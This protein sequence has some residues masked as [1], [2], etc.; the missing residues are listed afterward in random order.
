[1]PTADQVKTEIDRIVGYLVK[2]GLAG[3]QNYAIRRDMAGG[4]VE[5]SFSG[6]EYVAAAMKDRAYSNVY[7]QF[8]QAR[9]Y[10]AKMPDGALIQMLYKFSGTAIQR[11]R[12]AFFPSPSL[13]E[14]QN[15]PEIYLED[16]LYADVI[17]GSIVPFPIRFDFDDRLG[18]PKA[19]IHPRSHLTLGQYENCRIPVTA[20]VTPIRFIE[21]ILRNFYNTAFCRY[22]EGLPKCNGTFSESIYDSE[23]DVVHLVIPEI[24]A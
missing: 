24:E 23:R 15:H 16:E 18:V 21:F 5:I 8:T 20:P 22:S 14:F 1:M 9:A 12:L 17:G 6:A 3:D 4:E 11:H 10:N 2:V 13:E 19:L 7:E